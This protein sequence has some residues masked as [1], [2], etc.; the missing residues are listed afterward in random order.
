MV[1]STDYRDSCCR[2]EARAGWADWHQLAEIAICQRV[3]CDEQQQPWPRVVEC[4][5]A[6]PV[7]LEN[8]LVSEIVAMSPQDST[9]T[10]N[11]QN[12]TS[13]VGL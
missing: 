9:S 13:G 7:P 1:T 6:G 3:P 8:A 11:E 5:L 12:D 4:S 10:Q 2:R